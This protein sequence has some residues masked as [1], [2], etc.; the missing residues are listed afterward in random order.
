MEQDSLKVNNVFISFRLSQF[1]FVHLSLSKVTRKYTSRLGIRTIFY[2]DFAA[3]YLLINYV[4]V[5]VEV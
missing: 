4:L 5:V 3:Y 1:V 2:R